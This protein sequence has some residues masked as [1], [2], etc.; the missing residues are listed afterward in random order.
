[1]QH[2]DNVLTSTKQIFNFAYAQQ[3]VMCANVYC[4]TKNRCLSIHIQY[5]ICQIVTFA[6]NQFSRP[7]RDLTQV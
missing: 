6:Y 1:M 4:H 2:S 3:N 5:F 7:K